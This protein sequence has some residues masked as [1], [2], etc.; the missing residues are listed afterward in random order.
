[1]TGNCGLERLVFGFGRAP[2]V[3]MCSLGPSLFFDILLGR[4]VIFCKTGP[5]RTCYLYTYVHIY[6][7]IIVNIYIYI[8]N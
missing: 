4:G 5:V 8:S 7:Y 6:I 2:V 1:M 3:L